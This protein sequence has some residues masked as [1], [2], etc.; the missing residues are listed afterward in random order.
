M[1]GPAVG[2]PCCPG[3]NWSSCQV[4]LGKAEDEE[5]PG[6]ST[7]G[8]VGAPTHSVVLQSSPPQPTSTPSSAKEEGHLCGSHLQPCSA[9]EGEGRRHQSSLCAGSH[10]APLWRQCWAWGFL[11]RHGGCHG[12][13]WHSTG[14]GPR[15]A[16]AAARATKLRASEP[17][18]FPCP[19]PAADR[20]GGHSPCPASEPAGA[21]AARPGPATPGQSLWAASCHASG[22]E[23]ASGTD[24]EQQ[25]S[26]CMLG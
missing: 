4:S 5:V 3:R 23:D 14:V 13:M 9:Q 1:L 19:A 2:R 24:T 10:K 8:G 22:T 12:V 17:S 26:V 15:A 16:P 18:T 6:T 21:T 20:D 7:D 25:Q 11:P